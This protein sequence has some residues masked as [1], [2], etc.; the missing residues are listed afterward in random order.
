MSSV[1]CSIDSLFTSEASKH[2]IAESIKLKGICT[3]FNSDEMGL[4]SDIIMNRCVILK[5]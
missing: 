4:G 2:N 1:R 3:G 5:K